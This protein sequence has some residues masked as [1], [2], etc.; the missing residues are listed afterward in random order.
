MSEGICSCDTMNASADS[1]SERSCMKKRLRFGAVEIKDMP[2]VLGDNTPSD[3]APISI[4]WKAESSTRHTTVDLLELCKSHKRDKAALRLS[5]DERVAVLMRAGY[6]FDDIREA[7]ENATERR[8]QREAS[9]RQQK[10]EFIETASRKVKK[11]VKQK[12]PN[13]SSGRAA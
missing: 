7:W 4:G 1:F 12:K 8:K 6:S 9:L 13:I 2:I 10:W 3:G 11:L 5:P